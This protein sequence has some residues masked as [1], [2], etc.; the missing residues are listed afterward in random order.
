MV[1]HPVLAIEHAGRLIQADVAEGHGGA[2]VAEQL[3]NAVV[4]AETAGNAP[5]RNRVGALTGVACFATHDA[6]LQRLMGDGHTLVEDLP[7]AVLVSVGFQCDAR[8]V[9]GDHA[10]VHAAVLD[11]LAG[12]RVDPALQEAERQPIGVLKEPVIFTMFS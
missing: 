11:I 5:K 9:H 4:G 12:L 6:E 3:I 8:N 7:E 1:A 2:F 10:E